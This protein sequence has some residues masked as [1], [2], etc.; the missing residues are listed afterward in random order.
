M[1]C[2]SLFSYR[3]L[4]V[5]YSFTSNFSIFWSLFSIVRLVIG[6]SRQIYG[7]CSQKQNNPYYRD[8]LFSVKLKTVLAKKVVIICDNV[9]EFVFGMHIQIFYKDSKP[10]MMFSN[11]GDSRINCHRQIE[12]VKLHVINIPLFL[13][14]IV[15]SL[16]AVI[17]HHSEK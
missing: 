8:I 13:H 3:Q 7:S 1:L 2:L 16:V 11:K 17:A 5:I 4:C 9:Y 6:Y 12:A 14:N 15:R 10:Y